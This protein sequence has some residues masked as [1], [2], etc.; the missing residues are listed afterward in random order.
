MILCLPS[1]KGGKGSFEGGT[2]TTNSAAVG[3]A[4]G[5]GFHLIQGHSGSD[6]PTLSRVCI[7]Q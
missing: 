2:D 5:Y 1:I 7:S 3:G 6:D 4:P